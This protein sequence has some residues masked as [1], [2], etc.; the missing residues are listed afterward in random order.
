MAT[1]KLTFQ[2]GSTVDFPFHAGS[3]LSV[4]TP[5]GANGDKYG[6]WG[7]I[8]APELTGDAAVPDG[9]VPA[10]TAITDIPATP[11][12][13]AAGTSNPDGTVTPPASDVVVTTPA[14]PADATNPDGTVTSDSPAAALDNAAVLPEADALAHINAA[15]VKWP[16]DADLLAAQADLTPTA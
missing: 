3:Q 2:D 4:T 9:T 1:L 6:S 13:T 10:P 16:D 8:T 7:E 14:D 11:D 12:A 5:D 15:L